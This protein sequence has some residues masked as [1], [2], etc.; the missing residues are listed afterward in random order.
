[1]STIIPQRVVDLLAR[2]AQEV[3]V[4]HILGGQIAVAFE[5]ELVVDEAL[6]DVTL[7][8]RLH[9]YSA[10]KPTVSLTVLE[11]AAEGLIDLDAP[12]AGV[13]PSFGNEGKAEITLSQV[14]LHA[15]GFP[16]A[17][18]PHELW[19]DRSARLERYAT[20]RT[21]WAPG[22]AFEYHASSA[23]WVLADMITEVTGRHHADVVTERVM[24]PAGASR[25]LAIPED[26]QADVADVVAIG[27]APDPAAFREKFGIDMPVTEVTPE[28][29]VAFNDPAIRAAGQPGGG[30]IASAAG[31]ALWYQAIMHDDGE[32][33]RPEVKT[34]ALTVVRQN[35]MDWLG[36]P[37]SRT[38]AFILG[39]E[40]TTKAARGFGHTVSAAAF[41]HNGASGQRI[42]AD[43]ESGLSIA[44]MT[45]GLDRNDMVY[46]HWGTAISSKA[47]LLTT[48]LD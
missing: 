42:C 30:G 44:M 16:H 40:Q 26:Q 21:S 4:G 3:D 41:G 32:I 45:R 29:L 6:G 19:A 2:C 47:G 5:G 37:A 15:G 28:A 34:D 48:P 1:M 43:P 24:E 12:V 18:M 23:H 39:G 46:N 10:V 13:L 31:V 36:A 8:Q 27:T 33:L 35:H 11:L 9:T 7:D 20:W 25:W 22:T 17:P 38:H 14:L